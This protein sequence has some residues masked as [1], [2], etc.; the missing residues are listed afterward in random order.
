MATHNSPKGRPV[1]M[2]IGNGEGVEDR[3][4]Q[5]VNLGAA[6]SEAAGLLDRLVESGTYMQ[7]QAVDK[8]REASGE[9]NV[10]LG[11]A[12]ELYEAVGPFIR[13]YGS[14]VI[15]A[16]SRMETSVAE[17]D[18]AWQVY[19][20][21]MSDY[22][23]AESTPVVYPSGVEPSDDGSARETAE[24][25]HG[26][27]V[28]EALSAQN[29]AYSLWE[30]AGEAFDLDYDY[31]EGE[32]NDA[33]SGVQLSTADGIADDFWDN[34]DG[35]VDF[36]LGVLAVAGVVL[37]VLA[38]VVA[39]PIVAL[40]ALAV[41]VLALIGTI[42]QYNRGDAE[43]WEVGLAV[44]GVLPFGAI[45]EFA[46]GGFGAGMRAW[47]GLGRGGLSFGDDV[48]RWSLSSGSAS[49][50]DWIANMRTLGPEAGF[51]A[52][53]FADIFTTAM[54]GQDP[55]MWEVVG[56]L[57][58]MGQQAA[59]GLPTVGVFLNNLNTVGSGINGGIELATDVSPIRWPT[60]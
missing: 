44:L 22:E 58:T 24:Q 27:A 47:T 45:G 4:Q 14:A 49:M 18:A 41:G 10:E 21:R 1:E 9:V 12:A 39:G 15:S 13:Q 33:V 2:L 29:A 28:S 35:F 5:I 53:N 30:T 38:M 32:F 20:Q 37:A 50:G 42:Y 40:L 26:T 3:G 8:L 54:S 11:L 36:A 19:Q 34:L 59:Y 46:S 48:A 51:A 25:D 55:F 23:D 16:Q 31:W 56:E 43:L 57:A 6:M 7:G 17:A 60:W 52:N